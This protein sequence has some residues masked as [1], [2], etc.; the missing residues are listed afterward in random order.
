MHS[1][2]PAMS[3]IGYN[4]ARAPN[5]ALA[6]EL[7]EFLLSSA[8]MYDKRST[9]RIFKSLKECFNAAYNQGLFP[10]IEVING[11][12]R[13]DPQIRTRLYDI[14]E[15]H[16]NGIDG[17]QSPIIELDDRMTP[18]PRELVNHLGD[19]GTQFANEPTFEALNEL[20][21]KAINIT[22]ETSNYILK[23]LTNE[24]IQP[25]SNEIHNNLVLCQIFA[26]VN[27][28]TQLRDL[29]KYLNNSEAAVGIR[30]LIYSLHNN[31]GLYEQFNAQLER[32][33]KICLHDNNQ[34]ILS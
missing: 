12:D 22:E 20:L 21:E 25:L 31:T 9:K 2:E 3:L 16:Q 17:V 15:N 6:E 14:Y 26:Q 18:E 8:E 24:L 34:E 4:L 7:I 30:L 5:V 32:D 28:N 29:T 27:T 10:S 19:I 13:I 33:L 1:I 23:C 11:D